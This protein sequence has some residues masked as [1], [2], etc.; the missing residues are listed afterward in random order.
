M[1]ESNHAFPAQNRACVCITSQCYDRRGLDTSSPLPLFTSLYHLTYLTSTSARIRE[2]MTMD[3]AIERLMRILYDYCLCPPPP[4]SP[5]YIYGLSPPNSR[6]PKLIP[7]MNPAN[8][9]KHAAY[10]FSL[11]LQSIVN[12]GI[13]GSE[14]IRS[15]IVQAGALEVVGCILEAWLAHKGFAIGPSQSAS[16]LPRESR[17]QRLAR[18]AA[19]QELRQR[20]EAVQ[21]HRALQRQIAS[22]ALNRTDNVPARVDRDNDDA[23]MTDSAEPSY[24]DISI[25]TDPSPAPVQVPITARQRP[26]YTRHSSS[27][28]HG[29]DADTSTETS[30]TAT[31][32]GTDTPPVAVLVNARERSGTIIARRT[33]DDPVT[34]TATLRAR[35]HRVRPTTVSPDGSTDNSRPETETEDDGDADVDMSQDTDDSAAPSAPR[36]RQPSRSLTLTQRPRRAVGIVSDVPGPA[37]LQ[38]NTDAHIIIHH[39]QGGVGVGDG[40]A[41]GVEDGI[42]SLEP[43]DDFAMGAP[44]GA[45]G[46]MDETIPAR[47]LRGVDVPV[48]DRRIRNA[49]DATPRATAVPL[50]LPATTVLPSAPHSEEPAREGAAATRGE[51]PTPTATMNTLRTSSHHHHHRDPD[52]GPFRDEDVLFS[53][54][55]LAYLSK[56]PHVRQAF[57]KP[58]SSFHPAAAN[59]APRAPQ[60]Q[61]VAGPSGTRHLNLNFNLKTPTPL[62]NA[63]PVPPTPPAKEQ[64]G[65]FRALA[66][67]T[68][69]GKEKEKASSVAVVSAM[70][71]PPRMTNVFSLVER[72]T[73]RPSSTESELPNPPPKLP[74][75]ISYWAGVI[76]RNACRKDDSRGGIRQ[77]AN[78]LCGR[79]ETYPREFAKCRR[80]RKAKYCGKE[81]QS[82]AWSEGHRFWCSAKEGEEAEDPAEHQHPSVE[83][84]DGGADG[85]ILPSAAAAEAAQARAERRAERERQLRE[86]ERMT[87]TIPANHIVPEHLLIAPLNPPPVAAQLTVRQ[88]GVVLPP[89][90][91]AAV[92]PPPGRGSPSAFGAAQHNHNRRRAETVSGVMEPAAIREARIVLAQNPWQPPV[93]RRGGEEIGHGHAHGRGGQEM[94]D[95]TTPAGDE[96][97][98]LG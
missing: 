36:V 7:T 5:G 38:V 41:V 92:S 23:T 4:E 70:V 60:Q 1:R 85:D 58:R 45:P 64:Y 13:R 16:G 75:E 72:F 32:Q 20:E 30:I 35:P 79:W 57:Y 6:P 43:N 78:M 73:F 69:R 83:R 68:A 28:S 9:D 2:I 55:L 93:R 34:A 22:D 8:Y 91:Q 49:P 26:H 47:G 24:S 42:V 84:H 19:I 29:T 48:T 56:Y 87:G 71:A 11:A 76:M 37:P 25:R 66:S 31:P 3:G 81:C 80:C 51:H 44:P 97:M 67:A 74:S 54:Q 65:F 17:E 89:A 59:L 88:R 61:P 39:E 82:T 63:I 95:L 10:R 46:A 40:M 62:P 94:W 96:D 15:R 14:P 98:V 90:N 18:R 86:R 12:I 52:Q 53:L 21:L 77:C 50:P 27:S 33:W